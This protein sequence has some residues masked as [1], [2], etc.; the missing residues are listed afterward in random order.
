[1][2]NLASRVQQSARLQSGSHEA[3][4]KGTASRSGQRLAYSVTSP[5]KAPKV[6]LMR[7][8]IKGNLEAMRLWRRLR[9]V[10]VTCSALEADKIFEASRSQYLEDSNEI[11][12]IL[13]FNK[14]HGKITV[15]STLSNA[16]LVQD[17]S[18]P[19]SSALPSSLPPLRSPTKLKQRLDSLSQQSRRNLCRRL[20][21][22]NQL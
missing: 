18:S 4:P 8:I 12:H 17:L 1:M 15:R 6:H 14:K 9:Q 5:K 11:V 7:L 22:S 13:T 3:N 10:G 20:Q 21:W 2:C 19:I 16:P